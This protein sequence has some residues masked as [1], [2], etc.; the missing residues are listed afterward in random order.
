[1]TS[2]E[3]QIDAA[4]DAFETLSKWSQ[5]MTGD[6]L[7]AHLRTYV[8]KPDDGLGMSWFHHPLYIAFLPMALPTT[9][10]TYLAIR[11]QAV[12]EA[13]RDGEYGAAVFRH[14]RPYRMAFLLELLADGVWEGSEDDARLA[15]DF[16]KTASQVWRDAE[17]DERDPIWTSLANAPVAHPALM[18]D[19]EERHALRTMPKVIR[20]Y[21]GVQVKRGEEPDLTSM[22]NGWSWTL[23]R[24]TAKWFAKRFR[25]PGDRSY[26]LSTTVP[27]AWVRAY[28]TGRGEHEILIE[29]GRVTR[30][31]VALVPA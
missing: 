8:Q 21:R 9:I 18:M 27:K 6:D 20:I 24:D 5:Y 28:L 22:L 23:R 12:D 19:I 7:P 29:P 2:L 17:A 15:N 3:Q 30:D 13:I 1:M 10:E 31:T 14:E 4:R 25:Q 26:V 11:E 16:W